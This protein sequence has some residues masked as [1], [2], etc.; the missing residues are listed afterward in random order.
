MST[1]INNPYFTQALR[2]NMVLDAARLHTCY[3]RNVP[4]LSQ[5]ACTTLHYIHLRTIT[6]TT[7]NQPQAKAAIATQ[8]V[9]FSD[10]KNVTLG[11]AI[12]SLNAV[13]NAARLIEHT[14]GI[15]A[16]KAERYRE[17]VTIADAITHNQ[18]M[19]DYNKQAQELG[20][21]F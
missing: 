11:T 6:M 14:T 9:A 18:L 13:N 12:S 5:C 7:A 15:L 19:A 20:L 4:A 10:L 16:D 3:C 2:L 21:D 1:Y 8:Q 17:Q